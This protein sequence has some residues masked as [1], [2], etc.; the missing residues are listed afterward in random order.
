[1]RL[2]LLLIMPVAFGQ[3]WNMQ[4]S[5]ASAPLRG[6][7]VVSRDVAWASGSGGTF[8]RTVDGGKTWKASV[9]PGAG[10]LDFR[11]VQA[12]SRE[13]AFLM[14]SGEGKKSGVY[15][16]VDAG[17][18]WRVV[19]E[20]PDDKGFFDA[21]VLRDFRNGL[22]LGDPV[23]GTFVIYSAGA[24]GGRFS[25]LKR[26]ASLPGEGAFA[27]SNSALV[28]RGRRIWFA[29]GGKTGSRVFRSDDAGEHWA[30]SQTPVRSGADGA[31]IFSI[32]FAD[33][34]NG[35]A[36]GGDYSKAS[37]DA[38]NVAITTDGGVTWTEPTGTRPRGYRSGVAWLPEHRIWITTGTTGSEV[39][40]DGGRNWK[41][42]DDGGFN[43]IGV[44]P[45]DACWAVGAKG[46]I[47]KLEFER[48]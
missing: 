9:V 6:V 8:L 42:F 48:K 45:G 7:S 23:N 4:T 28:V 22:L 10:E 18:G 30:V 39:S 3:T 16:T 11:G 44:G 34:R 2:L 40:S 35:I 36:V 26:P 25:H 13:N 29:T 27:A 19:S 38:H 17:K 43:A 37:E 20:D 21:L 47:A 31:G 32:A 12:F 5:G 33:A 24:E 1:M 41:P 15:R 14:A 46:R